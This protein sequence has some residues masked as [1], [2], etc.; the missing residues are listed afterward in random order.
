MR[1][2]SD[3]ENIPSSTG[4][5]EAVAKV[6]PASAVQGKLAGMAFRVPTIDD[7]VK[8]LTCKLNTPTTYAP[9]PLP[10]SL[11]PTPSPYFLCAILSLPIFVQLSYSVSSVPL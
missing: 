5:A 3:L 10:H 2:K 7:S 4:T 11:C 8:E 6:I 1:S 9:F